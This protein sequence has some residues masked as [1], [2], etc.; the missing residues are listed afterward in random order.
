MVF[1]VTQNA[2]YYTHAIDDKRRKNRGTF[3]SNLV[4]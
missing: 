2:V 3:G 1:I 4:H